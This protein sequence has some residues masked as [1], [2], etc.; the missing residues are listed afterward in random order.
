MSNR[1]IVILGFS[2]AFFGNR[3][4]A[5]QY[6]F[7]PISV[8]GSV[9]GTTDA[10]GIS[11]QDVVGGYEIA[12]EGQEGFLYN[13]DSSTYVS[14]ID[15]QELSGADAYTYAEA[16]S[17]S[18]VAGTYQGTNADL[19]GFLYNT[20]THTYTTLDDPSVDHTTGYDAGT[21]ATGIDGNYV[22]GYYENLDGH[23]GGGYNGFVF[24]IATGIYTTLDL[25]GYAGYTILNGISG[26]NI[27]GFQN[28]TAGA[29]F[30]YSLTS[31]SFSDIQDPLGVKGTQP[32]GGSGGDVVGTYTDSNGDYNG[33]LFD[34]ASYST[35]DDPAS[36]PSYGGTA[37][38]G[39]SDGDLVG[40]YLTN[41]QFT[42]SSFVAIPVPEP[43]AWELLGG[44]SVFVCFSPDFPNE[45]PS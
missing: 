14:L 35:I 39:I 8:P 25:P 32:V 26:D 9:A 31:G 37:I 42:Y 22:V 41:Q 28:Q 3:A 45:L 21:V 5:Q 36:N 16:I 15:P 1:L 40:F 44:I 10:L 11:G 17:G 12:D 23:H 29:G 4:F 38:N 18:E 2:L 13:M 7:S 19:Y 6:T 43:S 20:V 24:N 33:F 27:F 34:G 30:E